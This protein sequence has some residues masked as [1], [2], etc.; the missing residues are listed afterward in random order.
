MA[1]DIGVSIPAAHRMFVD[2]E[3]RHVYCFVHNIFLDYFYSFIMC[4]SV[5]H[6]CD[7]VV[8]CSKTVKGYL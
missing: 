4:S 7:N 1:E 6:T 5:P 2:P 3:G 8:Q